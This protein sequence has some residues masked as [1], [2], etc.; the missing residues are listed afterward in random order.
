VAEIDILYEDNHLLAL[1]KPAGLATQESMHNQASLEIL[2]KAYIKEAYQ[3]PGNVFVQPIHRLDKP[4]SGIV[5]FAKTSKSLS[6]L[7]EAMRHHQLQ[8]TYLALV[9]GS[10]TP[11]DGTLKHALVH[12][13]HKAEVAPEGKMAILHYQTRENQDDR[14]LLEINL[15]TGRYHQIR[16]QFA[17]I[18]HPVVGDHKYGAKSR[19]ANDIIRLHHHKLSFSHPVT[20]VPIEILSS[21]DHAN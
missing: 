20:H 14:T 6:R 7:Q 3:K 10:V 8:K 12:L 19:L 16:A 1:D 5:L 2:A 4:T 13:E 17:H 9:E 18:G 11:K 21:W 15:C